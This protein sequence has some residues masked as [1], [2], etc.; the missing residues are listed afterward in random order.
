MS[1]KKESKL[2]QVK[3]KGSVF[4]NKK[5]I[6]L[7]T[8][9]VVVTV[10]LLVII[11][12]GFLKGN[13]T[14][15]EPPPPYGPV[16]VF[17]LSPLEA[18]KT[19]LLSE[20]VKVT[21]DKEGYDLV[22]E[23]RVK[24]NGPTDFVLPYDHI[25]NPVPPKILID[26]LAI[27]YKSSIHPMAYVDRPLVSSNKVN[28]QSVYFMP[29][30]LKLDKQPDN[31]YELLL[32]SLDSR[33]Y[34]IDLD[35]SFKIFD[36]TEIKAG[37]PDNPSF[38][39]AGASSDLWMIFSKKDFPVLVSS[40][41]EDK[42]EGTCHYDFFIESQTAIEK[43][44]A[45]LDGSKDVKLEVENKDIASKTM[46]LGAILKQ[47]L[48]MAEDSMEDYLKDL[49]LYLNSDQ[50]D[51]LYIL[52]SELDIS[53][54]T[55]LDIA[56]F[57]IEGPGEYRITIKLRAAKEGP[58][59]D[60]YMLELADSPSAMWSNTGK[61]SVKVNIGS[62]SQTYDIADDLFRFTKEMPR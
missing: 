22:M 23:Y 6:Y 14:L 21:H 18:G 16:T 60:N 25:N 50:S 51:R 10:I 30:H 46:T 49:S 36:I 40:W 31:S 29:D 24:T 41:H 43:W 34:D 53:D 11:L 28:K 12:P 15:G 44:F 7:C 35:T 48:Q 58:F 2:F 54:Q 62:D 20:Q 47:K 61:R 55:R 19:E 56:S 33:A 27:D 38:S 4:A 59:V 8:A 13:R 45:V 17:C 9:I 37:D 39:V 42:E 3:G 5:T 32:A 1:E 52:T 26:D 57:Q